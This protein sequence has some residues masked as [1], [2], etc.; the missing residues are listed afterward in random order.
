M[1]KPNDR[2]FLSSL[3]DADR[4]RLCFVPLTPAPESTFDAA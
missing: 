2:F 4:R 1:S 3:R